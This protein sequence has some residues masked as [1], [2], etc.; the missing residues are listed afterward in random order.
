MFL[1]TLKN[2]LL[3][4]AHIAEVISLELVGLDKYLESTNGSSGLVTTGTPLVTRSAVPMEKVSDME[5]CIPMSISEHNCRKSCRFS[6][7][8]STSSAS[9]IASNNA[10]RF[11]RI[12]PAFCSRRVELM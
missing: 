5:T 7:G 9:G 2:G 8:C 11:F 12:G 10:L 1:L 6:H 4:A 3:R